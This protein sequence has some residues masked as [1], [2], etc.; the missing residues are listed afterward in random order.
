MMLAIL[1]MMAIAM[2]ILLLPYWI[3][4]T[5]KL[6]AP[7]GKWS[8][9]TSDFSWD[10]PQPAG[11]MAQVWYPTDVSAHSRSP[12][13][14]KIQSNL[15]ANKL[16][17]LLFR[18]IV[19]R[20][21][22][23]RITTPAAVQVIP[24]HCLEGFPVILFSPGFGGSI[25]LN[26]FYA[27]ELASQGFI[28]VGINHPGSCVGTMLTDGTQIEFAD[29]DPESFADVDRMESLVQ[30]IASEQASNMSKVV[31]KLISLNATA[32]SLLYQKING[33]QVFAA[34]HSAGGAAS[35]IAC[36]QDQRITKGV[37]LDGYF[38]DVPGTNYDHKELLLIQADRDRYRPKNK[39]TRAR[40]DLFAAKDQVRI[41]K[42]AAQANL[43]QLMIPYTKH[44]DFS[45][46]PVLLL[47][48]FSRTLGLSGAADGLE[49]SQ[50]TARTM[51]DFFQSSAHQHQSASTI[52]DGHGI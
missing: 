15:A 6:P 24:S 51:I 33:H 13:L 14:G 52:E 37:N 10:A 22:L 27:L 3:I 7:T 5:A 44:F 23:G 29:V 49:L 39:K 41:E 25:S 30:K 36:G 40:Y 26:T 18:L 2:I 38:V 43:Q 28:V 35:F 42:L 50:T 46:L 9:G 47:P 31:D 4:P 12:Y 34:G 11:I 32:D 19:S 45:D 1:V 48:T 17:N 8:V 16:L 20:S 21:L